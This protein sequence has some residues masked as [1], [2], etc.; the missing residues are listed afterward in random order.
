MYKIGYNH[1]LLDHFHY[2]YFLE[3]VLLILIL[4]RMMLPPID[5]LLLLRSKLPPFLNLVGPP[6]GDSG[7]S[8]ATEFFLFRIGFVFE[9]F[10]FRISS[11]NFLKSYSEFEDWK[12]TFFTRAEET[13][14]VFLWSGFSGPIEF[15]TFSFESNSKPFT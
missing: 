9:K 4:G 10:S 1:L 11:S 12:S 2:L 8:V 15:L 13:D 6:R 7:A 5:M 14:R 3:S